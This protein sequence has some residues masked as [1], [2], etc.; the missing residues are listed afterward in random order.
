MRS[1]CSAGICIRNSFRVQTE[2]LGITLLAVTGNVISLLGRAV[3]MV[4]QKFV[5]GRMLYGLCVQMC[6]CVCA[7]E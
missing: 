4:T 1:S 5:V 2:N 3:V 7:C 6:V